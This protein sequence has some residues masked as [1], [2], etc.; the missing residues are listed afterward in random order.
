MS[1]KVCLGSRF[2][3]KENLVLTLYTSSWPGFSC[4]SEGWLSWKTDHTMS[5]E[6]V[7]PFSPFIPF[8]LQVTLTRNISEQPIRSHNSTS[9]ATGNTSPCCTG[10]LS[11][12]QLA[13]RSQFIFPYTE[14]QFTV[15]HS[16]WV[17][18]PNQT[19]LPNGLCILILCIILCYQKS[20][21]QAI[22]RNC[23]QFSEKIGYIWGC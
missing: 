9:R 23:S 4:G 8:L 18:F 10:T 15:T 5:R 16:I 19:P 11:T 6:T 22:N 17:C 3:N 7:V 2:E 12:G 14:R 20:L 21:H 1:K 13:F